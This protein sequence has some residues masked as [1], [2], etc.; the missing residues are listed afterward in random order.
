[1]TYFNKQDP[2]VN[3]GIL[4]AEEYELCSSEEQLFY[5]GIALGIQRGK[6]LAL[7]ELEAQAALKYPVYIRRNGD[8]APVDSKPRNLFKAGFE[9]VK[10]GLK[11]LNEVNTPKK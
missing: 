1:M 7:E 2:A 8:F 6:L 5:D 11:K 10:T 9:T 4:T 3:A